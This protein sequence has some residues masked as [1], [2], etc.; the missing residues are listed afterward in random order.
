MIQRRTAVAFPASP[1]LSTGCGG[2][3]DRRAA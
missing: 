3:A 1:L 2:G